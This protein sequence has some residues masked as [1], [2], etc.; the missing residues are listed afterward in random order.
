MPAC[1]F[2]R[3]TGLQCPGCG[4]QRAFHAACQGDWAEAF[5]YNLLLPFAILYSL[6]LLLLPVFR[7]KTTTKIYQVIAGPTACWIILA[8]ILAWWII[9]N[10]I[11]I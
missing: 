1:L 5:G 11:N 10:F 2:H 4:A 8:V 7:N 9:R 6:A 3:F